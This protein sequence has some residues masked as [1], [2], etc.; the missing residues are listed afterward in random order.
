MAIIDKGNHWAVYS[1]VVIVACLSH[2]HA[3]KM[4]MSVKKLVQNS[5]S[6]CGIGECLKATNA[7][8]QCNESVL[9]WCEQCDRQLPVTLY[10][11][12]HV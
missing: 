5:L 11:K 4:N 12:S 10:S 6:F 8:N 7:Q 2:W 9:Y 1:P 3:S